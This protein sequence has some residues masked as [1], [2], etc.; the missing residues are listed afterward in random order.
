MGKRLKSNDPE[1]IQEWVEAELKERDKS[2]FVD[3]DPN[4][5]R[6]DHVEMKDGE[7]ASSDFKR[8]LLKNSAWGIGVG[9]FMLIFEAAKSGAKMSWFK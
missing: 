9:V 5:H 8:T 6:I 2:A 7:K 4:A 1:D 3:A